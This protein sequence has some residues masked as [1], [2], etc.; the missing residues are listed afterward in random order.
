VVDNAS[1]DNTEEVVRSISDRR[2]RYVR[3]PKNIGLIPN[4]NRAYEE[5]SGELIAIYHDHDLYH[6]D[7]VR[8]SVEMFD[9]HPNVGVVAPAV[10]WVNEGERNKIV[11]T[12]I[13]P[14][15]AVTPGRDMRRLLLH[16]WSSPIM[17]PAAM[18][19]RICYEQNGGCFNVE[20]GD[21]GDRE[22][23]MRLLK[24]WDFGYI[25]EPMATFV[26]RPRLLKGFSREQAEEFWSSAQSHMRMHRMYLEEDYGNKPLQYPIERLRLFYSSH[27]CFWVAALWCVA[28]EEREAA[29][30]AVGAFHRAGMHVSAAA[31]DRMRR[32]SLFQ[33]SLATAVRIIRS[34]RSLSRTPPAY[35]PGPTGSTALSGGQ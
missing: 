20:F 14:W 33:R 29:G 2:L 16:Q 32:S 15:K 34:N 5:A 19:R 17:A 18:V 26:R 23:W 35:T 27:W 11:E 7:L 10:H 21:C 6:L 3:N 22:M 9:R 8:R 28:K 12:V 25:A 31:F 24:N 1:T 30:L 4:Q 13:Q